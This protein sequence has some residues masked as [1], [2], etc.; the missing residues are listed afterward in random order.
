MSLTLRDLS[1][2]LRLEPLFSMM[3]SFQMKRCSLKMW[4]RS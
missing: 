2:I 1:L 4:Q 3:R